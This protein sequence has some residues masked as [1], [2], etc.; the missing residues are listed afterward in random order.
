VAA[1]C[2]SGDQVTGGGFQGIAEGT[3]VSTSTAF[4]G[5]GPNVGLETWLVQIVA[6]DDGDGGD[7][8]QAIVSCA[9]FPPLRP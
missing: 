1:P 5:F 4:P 3:H 9:D 8:I 7:T 6:G 2:D